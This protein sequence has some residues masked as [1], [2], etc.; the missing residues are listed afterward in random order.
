MGTADSGTPGASLPTT[1]HPG[2][3][4]RNGFMEM[5]VLAMLEDAPYT[6]GRNFPR[7]AGLGHQ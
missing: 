4:G 7:L 3:L 6:Q 1:P 5:R 2:L